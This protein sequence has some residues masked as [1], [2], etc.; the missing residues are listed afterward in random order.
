M[1]RSGNIKIFTDIC[2]QVFNNIITQNQYLTPNN[3]KKYVPTSTYIF[4]GPTAVCNTV[5]VGQL[6]HFSPIGIELDH[7]T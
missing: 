4:R 1:Y 6:D 2:T 5:S 7:W 3:W